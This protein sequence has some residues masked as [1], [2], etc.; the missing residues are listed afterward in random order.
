MP[1][2]TTNQATSS[3]QSTTANKSPQKDR[4]NGAGGAH[5]H[6]NGVQGHEPVAAQHAGA[7]GTIPDGSGSKTPGSSMSV[8]SAGLAV[9]VDSVDIKQR[10]L[11]ELANNLQ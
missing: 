6:G 11:A 9:N 7:P 4:R 5:P 1:Q 3:S 10:S 8:L 2:I